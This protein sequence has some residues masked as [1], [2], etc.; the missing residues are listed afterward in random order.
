MPGDITTTT[1]KNHNKTNSN[2]SNDTKEGATVAPKKFNLV[3]ETCA[4]FTYKGQRL[5]IRNVYSDTLIWEMAKIR[6]VI[7]THKY[8]A[9][10]TEFPGI[11]VRPLDA[12]QGTREK[13]Y[14]TLRANVDLLKIIQLGLT[15][16]DENGNLAPGCP[17]WQF[18]FDFNVEVDLYANDSIELLKSSGIDFAQH[19][20]RGINPSIFAEM[21]MT[22]GLVLG[23]DTC[24]ITFQSGY[25]FGYLLKMLT[26]ADLPQTETEFFAKLLKFFPKLYDE[27]HMMCSCESLVG[28]LNRLGND[29]QVERIGTS[30]QAGSDSLLTAQTFFKMKQAVFGNKLDEKKFEGILHGYNDTFM[31]GN[32]TASVW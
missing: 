17:C 19:A 6:E 30:H 5:E 20:K 2:S 25:D 32:Q 28:G 1:N 23:P 18:N 9:M 8:I 16:C 4:K 31:G 3:S 10:D 22:S 11:V 14:K 24:W 13:N 27:K 15:F 7:T 26:G 12:Y 21:L 29:L